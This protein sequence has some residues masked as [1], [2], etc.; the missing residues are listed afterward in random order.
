MNINFRNI[1]LWL[2]LLLLLVLSIRGCQERDPWL[3]AGVARKVLT[4]QD[5]GSEWRV[6]TIEQYNYDLVGPYLNEVGFA[7]RDFHGLGSRLEQ[8][9]L[10]YRTDLG[11]TVGLWRLQ[12]RNHN[13]GFTVPYPQQKRLN[14][15]LFSSVD[16][17]ARGSDTCVIVIPKGNYLMEIVFHQTAM[18]A[19]EIDHVVQLALAKLMR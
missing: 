17:D 13:L 15:P 3:A 18:N 11:A 10:V 6:G 2:L 19:N 16:C 12:Q 1:T 5:L 7:I 9:I 14:L 8:S 4:A